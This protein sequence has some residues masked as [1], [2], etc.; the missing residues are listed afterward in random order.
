M[1]VNRCVLDEK[2]PEKL[3]HV[4]VAYRQRV[5]NEQDIM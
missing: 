5:H 1:D 2:M 3:F 4:F